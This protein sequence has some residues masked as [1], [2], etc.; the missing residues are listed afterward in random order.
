MNR[1]YLVPVLLASVF[2][3]SATVLS[4]NAVSSASPGDG[5][6]IVVHLSKYTNDLHAAFMAFKLADAMQQQGARVTVLVDLEGVRIADKR[7]PLEMRWGSNPATLAEVYDTFI[8]GGGRVILCP[9]CA[10]AAGVDGNALRDG[11]MIGVPDEQT[12]PKLL[13]EADKI[14]DY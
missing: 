3:F 11:A 7:N 2:A 1:N 8:N 5:Q 13:V 10:A 6:K 9:H 14:L 4:G 12:I